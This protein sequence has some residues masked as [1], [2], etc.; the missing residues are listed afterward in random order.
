[1]FKSFQT[2]IERQ[3]KY[4]IMKIRHDN[5][6]EYLSTNYLIYLKELDIVA[7]FITLYTS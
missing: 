3:S 6:E 4:K 1:M 5:E 2:K 7:K